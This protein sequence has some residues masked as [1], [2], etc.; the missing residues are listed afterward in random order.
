[1]VNSSNLFIDKNYRLACGSG[2]GDG[3]AGGGGTGGASGVGGAGGGAILVECAGSF[4]KAGDINAN[5]A[6]G[7][8]GA[9]DATGGS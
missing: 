1:M 9:D 6:N 5:G 2:G 7:T 8:D 3:F 4:S